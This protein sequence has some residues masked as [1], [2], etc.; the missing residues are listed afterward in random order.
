MCWRKELLPAF[1]IVNKHGE[2]SVAIRFDENA[3]IGFSSFSWRQSR[4][5]TWLSCFSESVSVISF[6]YIIVI[7]RQNYRKKKHILSR[8]KRVLIYA[9]LAKFKWKISYVLKI[10]IWN[11]E[12]KTYWKNNLHNLLA[13]I[14]YAIEF[15]LISVFSCH[16]MHHQVYLTC[17][18]LKSYTTYDYMTHMTFHVAHDQVIIIYEVIWCI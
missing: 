7:F 8:I 3:K 6:R 4:L 14:N 13:N 12:V 17:M 9:L 18:T 2:Q 15:S 11:R 10:N 1:S 16:R 5:R